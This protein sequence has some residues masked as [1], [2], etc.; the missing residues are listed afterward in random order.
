MEYFNIRGGDVMEG[1]FTP[2]GNKNEA[3]PVL[4]A[5]LLCNGKVVVKNV[6]DIKDVRIMLEIMSSLGAVVSK[7]SP[8][9]LEIDSSNIKTVP[10]DKELCGKIRTS[11]L[12]AGPLVARLG[13]VVLPL[14]GGDVI[15]RRRLDTHFFGFEQ[16]GASYSHVSDGYKIVASGKLKGRDIFL[17]EASVTAT[18]NIVMAAV[19]AEGTSVIK[20]AA[21]E[22]HV[23]GLCRFL[24]SMGAKISGVGTNVISVE[25]V[26]SLIGTEHTIGP[27]YIEA[28]SFISLCAMTGGELTVKNTDPGLS[29]IH[30]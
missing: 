13:S 18:E 24:N 27:D 15:G 30:I 14:P 21:S 22:P 7:K 1:E 5:S 8:N 20:N 23:Q 19:L 9:E 12:F 2:S 26:D 3:L 25:G 29:L 4:A 16:L 28:G 6:P 17:D 10:L 11:I